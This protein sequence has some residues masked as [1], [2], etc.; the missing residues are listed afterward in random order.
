MGNLLRCAGAALIL[1][2][3]AGCTSGGSP[4]AAPSPT[5]MTDAQLQAIGRQYS[6][7]IRDHGVPGFPDMVVVDGRMALPDDGGDAGKRALQA[8]P[9]AEQACRPILDQLPPSARKN[10]PVSAED[11]QNLLKFAQCLRENGVPEWPD[12]DSDG[13]FPIAGT[14]L[15]T[16]GKSPRMLTAMQACRQYW[17]RG[18]SAK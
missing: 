8:N 16:E 17:D 14:P 7:C 12:P 9:A 2:T 3:L 1:V 11:L 15:A 4:A 6:Q 5:A 13:A 18:I 10:G